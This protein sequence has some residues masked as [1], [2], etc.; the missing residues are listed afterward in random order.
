MD[1]HNPPIFGRSNWQQIFS[2]GEGILLI[3]K[4]A[5]ISSFGVVARV[6][7]ILSNYFGKKIKVG[8]AGTL[9]PFATG[10]LIV[11][12]GR[13][14]KLS[15]YLLK[16]D[17][18]YSATIFLGANSNTGDPEGEITSLAIKNP[19]SSSEIDSVLK[20]F[21]GDIDQVVPAFSAVKINGQRAY[22]LARQGKEIDLPTRSVHIYDLKKLSFKWPELSIDC[23]VS[24]GTYIRT[25]GED[26]GKKLQTGGYL[27]ALRRTSVDEYSV[28]QSVSLAEF[29]KFAS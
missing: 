4:P 1:I 7:R 28:G 19:P 24:S 3:D 14:T 21:I 16:K 26:I 29:M 11:L 5:G 20:T 17:K 25:L 27:T 8:H 2:T 13:A 12:V 23:R 18:S 6:R 9:D 22:R 15:Q 10:L